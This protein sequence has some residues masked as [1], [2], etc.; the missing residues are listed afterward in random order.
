MIRTLKWPWVCGFVVIT[1]LIVHH[2]RVTLPNRNRAGE[3]ERNLK[4]NVDP[5]ELRK[6][7]IEFMQGE[8]SAFGEIVTNVPGSL[9]RIKPS[10][11]HAMTFGEEGEPGRHVLLGWDRISPAIIIGRSNFVYSEAFAD[12]VTVWTNGIY[13]LAPRP[14]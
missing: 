1:F 5:E 2:V 13:I 6:W 10:H 14:Q 4:E 7:A 3:F 8:V 12:R 9:T 11:P